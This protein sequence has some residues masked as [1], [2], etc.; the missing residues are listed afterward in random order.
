MVH[1][2][3]ANFLG[4]TWLSDIFLLTHKKH[5][6]D[7]FLSSCMNPLILPQ[8][9]WQH[10]KTDAGQWHLHSSCSWPRKNLTKKHDAFLYCAL[11]WMLPFVIPTWLYSDMNT[12]KIHALTLEPKWLP[13][14]QQQSRIWTFFSRTYSCSGLLWISLTRDNNLHLYFQTRQNSIFICFFRCDLC[15]MGS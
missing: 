6:T 9:I 13:P 7:G 10:R 8:D 15:L 12:V 1:L 11:P 4:S 2:S 5:N 14:H 3:Q